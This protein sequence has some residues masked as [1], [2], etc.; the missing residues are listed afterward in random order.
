MYVS[1]DV[2]TQATIGF[3]TE[4]TEEI[5]V[6]PSKDYKL[7]WMN[8]HHTVRNCFNFYLFL[9]PIKMRYGDQA[10]KF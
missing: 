5:P 10:I 4:L 9:E 7:G 2:G 1:L 3:L 6:R 8:N